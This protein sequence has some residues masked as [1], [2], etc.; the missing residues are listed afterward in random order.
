[1][2]DGDA[3]AALRARVR[4]ARA[5]GERLFVRGGG[6]RTPAPD[7]VATLELGAHRGIVAF[8]PSEL[9]VTVRAGTPVAELEAVLA[10]AGQELPFDPPRTGPAATVGGA[11]AT[12]AAGPA[13]P[14]RGAVRDAVLG[15]TLLDGHGEIGRF[16]GAVMKNVAG[17][18]VS[19]LVAGARG[20][21]GAILETSLRVLPRPAARCTRILELGMDQAVETMTALAQ[22]PLPLQG[23]VWVEGFLHVRLGGTEEGVAAAAAS[24]GGEPLEEEAPFW[25]ALR[26]LELPAFAAD[27]P[28][29]RLS[30]PGNAPQPTLTAD[31]VL[32]WGGAQRWCVTAAEP[33][34][35]LAAAA[36][37]GGH[38]RRLRPAPELATAPAPAL[39]PLEAR[40]RAAF[41][42]DG[43]FAPEDR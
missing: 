43:V 34:R 19:R 29:W 10:E 39:A 15:V 13:R 1:M 42:P 7:G 23:L 4:E 14:W 5:A 22:R 30:V 35:V 6:T 20:T 28:L 36:E 26:D 2:A 37:L 9:V 33:E 27:V 31:W 17:Y 40:V 25:R 8:E 3:S 18:D 12:A 21:L 11:V 16:G 38:A 24:V 41:D 32:D